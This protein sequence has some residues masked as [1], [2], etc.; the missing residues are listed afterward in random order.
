MDAGNGARIDQRGM[1]AFNIGML[2]DFGNMAVAAAHQV[3][4]P[5]ACHADAIMR[6]VGDK[7]TAATQLQRGIHAMINQGS[8]GFCHQVVHGYRVALIVAV[9]HVYGYACFERSAQRV[10]ADDIAAVYNGLCAGSVG[11]TYGSGER[12][13]AIM[14]VGNNANFQFSGSGLGGVYA[15]Q[16]RNTG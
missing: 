5:G 4:I 7:D 6:I 16:R 8:C 3:V 2:C 12:F 15:L 10:C 13:C 1:A 11:R 9:Y 14:A